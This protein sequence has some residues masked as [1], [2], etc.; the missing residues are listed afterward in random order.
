MDYSKHLIDP[1][2]KDEKWALGIV[3]DYYNGARESW[4]YK[5]RQTFIENDKYF[6]GNMAV[7]KYQRQIRL[8]NEDIGMNVHINWEPLPILSHYMD[9]YLNLVYK[10]RF[11]NATA[12]D[13]VST[14]EKEDKKYKLQAKIRYKGLFEKAGEE[15][16]DI[17]IN[18]IDTFLELEPKQREEIA[19]EVGADYVF[20]SNQKEELFRE[21]D[22]QVARYGIVCAREYM[23]SDGFIVVEALDPKLMLLPDSK[24]KD[25][26]DAEWFGYERSYTIAE[27]ASRNPDLTNED[28]KKIALNGADPGSRRFDVNNAQ[29]DAAGNPI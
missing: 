17:A 2:K 29:V 7:A 18:E 3:E 6:E 9:I 27:I 21:L 8:P 5:R 28:L 24:F 1:K 26:R 16:P 4:L 13:P 11:V 20:Y 12:I 15:V 23:R 14:K 10:E 22:E 25:Y 19:I